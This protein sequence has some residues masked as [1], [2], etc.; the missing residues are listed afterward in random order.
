MPRVRTVDVDVLR[1]EL[2]T[3]IRCAATGALFDEPE[4]ASTSAALRR[5]ND[6]A[7]SGDGEPTTCPQFV[8]AV[9][10]V[11]EL[12]REQSLGGVKTVLITDACYLTRPAVIAGLEV[13]DRSNGEI[14]AKLD[15][16]T[17]DYYRL[18]NRPNYPLAH[19]VENIIHAARVRPV[20]IQSL[21]MRV[22]DVPP[23]DGEMDAYVLRL[24]D[25]VAAGGRIA[26]V[27]VYTVARPPAQ[28]FVTRLDDSEVERI[29]ERVQRLTG[30]AVESFGG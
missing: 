9:A 4:F 28:S 16:G 23:S 8:D 10:I 3:L 29:A 11:A 24:G 12:K 13:M 25:I 5:L 22:H 15:A 30:L 1:Q 26:R 6:I 17:E 7:F 21:F 27:Q 18:I 20:V 2:D 19:V 14:W